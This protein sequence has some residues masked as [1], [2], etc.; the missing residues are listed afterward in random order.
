MLHRAY[1]LTTSQITATVRERVCWT[2]HFFV[3]GYKFKRASRCRCK[4]NRSMLCC[5]KWMYCICAYQKSS[6]VFV[7]AHMC[8]N[9]LINLITLPV[10]VC[11]D[12]EVR[13]SFL[14]WR[15]QDRES[16]HSPILL[17]QTPGMNILDNL[18]VL[19]QN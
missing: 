17:G 16:R 1:L 6:Q 15:N 10:R 19:N 13:W 18:L 7:R 8:V 5:I 9:Y 11:T 2:L 4:N 14:E 3:F 12:W